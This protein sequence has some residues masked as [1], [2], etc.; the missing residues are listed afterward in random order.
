MR[1]LLITILIALFVFVSCGEDTTTTISRNMF[2]DTEGNALICIMVEDVPYLCFIDNNG[3]IGRQV[4]LS[5]VVASVV[6]M[7]EE[8]ETAKEEES[9]SM[10]EEVMEVIE[11][12]LNGMETMGGMK[13]DEESNENEEMVEEVVEMI[14]EE[15]MMGEESSPEE[16]AEVIMEA[17]ET[18]NEP[19]TGTQEAAGTQETAETQPP[20]ENQPGVVR[21]ETIDGVEFNVFE[22]GNIAPVVQF[23]LVRVYG[24]DGSGN[25]D[26]TKFK[27][28]YYQRTDNVTWETV[29]PDAEHAGSG[30]IALTTNYHIESDVIREVDYWNTHGVGYLA[31]Q[32]GERN[33]DFVFT[34]SGAYVVFTS[35]CPPGGT[36]TYRRRIV[37]GSEAEPATTDDVQVVTIDPGAGAYQLAQ[38]VLEFRKGANGN[39]PHETTLD[40]YF[41][42]DWALVFT[43]D[44]PTATEETPF[45]RMAHRIVPMNSEWSDNKAGPT[46]PSVPSGSTLYRDEYYDTKA[47]ALAATV[48][49]DYFP[50][51]NQDPHK[52]YSIGLYVKVHGEATGTIHHGPGDS[53][54]GFQ[55]IQFIRDA[56]FPETDAEKR[57]FIR[58]RFTSNAWRTG[59]DNGNTY[60]NFSEGFRTQAEAEAVKH[61]DRANATTYTGD[62]LD[63]RF[64]FETDVRTANAQRD[65]FVGRDV[66]TSGFAGND[67]AIYTD[68][69]DIVKGVMVV[70]GDFGLPNTV[71]LGGVALTKEEQWVFAEGADHTAI[72]DEM[73]AFFG[74]SN[75]WGRTSTPT[76]LTRVDPAP[77]LLVYNPTNMALTVGDPLNLYTITGTHKIKWYASTVAAAAAKST[78]EASA[79]IY[80]YFNVTQ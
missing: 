36:P 23:I 78:M 75:H 16:T 45:T 6:E 49:T 27:R 21:Q 56:D 76:A 26:D 48:N 51:P 43:P 12:E 80:T 69:N 7:M 57:Q 65:R 73:K 61:V 13:T 53:N 55:R 19:D 77:A 17:I 20:A 25:R 15:E 37:P 30:E 33:E 60:F 1:N 32:G 41:T 62:K 11:D 35:E 54:S 28:A 72:R 8:P 79:R 29:P 2:T 52:W 38:D 39:T 58:S 40:A 64:G 34:K 46:F 67:V 44:T 63:L 74:F 3:R 50:H 70:D 47:A 5:D 4:P 59:F 22:D 9:T 71:T 42:C 10:V 24:V 66:G 68:N 31:Y 14:V 18:V